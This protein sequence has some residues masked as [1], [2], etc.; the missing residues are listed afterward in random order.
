MLH[1]LCEYVAAEKAGMPTIFI[2]GYY[3]RT[4]V[5]GHQVFGD[6]RYLERAL[7]YGDWLLARQGGDGFWKT[8]YGDIYLADT[9][10]ALGLLMVLNRHADPGRQAR[11]RA[12][13]Q[14]Y[15]AAVQ[16]NRLIQ[17]SGAFGVGFRTKA[18]GT[19]LVP[20][21]DEYTISSALS[22]GVVCTWLY[23][24]TQDAR[25]RELAHQA[26]GWI[27]STQRDDGAIPY[28]L[29]GDG[30]DLAKR[31]DPATDFVLW[32]KHRF[33]AVAYVGEAVI[34]FDRYC[35]QPAWRRRLRDQ[36]GATVEFLLRT[37]NADGT[38][39]Y[40]DSENPARSYDQKRSPGVSHLLVWYYTNVRADDRVA[41]AVR[42]FNAF[43]LNRAN[44]R[45]FGLLQ[46]GGDASNPS[47]LGAFT[48]NDVVTALTGRALADM[49]QPGI[50]AHW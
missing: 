50:D 13:M 7:T 16:A 33:Q 3:M 4:L 49:L 41:A 46:A 21:R 2:G 28:V 10:S 43:L 38:W 39:G 26:L 11:Y 40:K 22:G 25:Y 47:P 44:Q 9:G 1:D 19:V 18:Q 48:Q 37:Q 8:G 29:K 23:H 6:R 42:R 14:R 30:G 27:M 34:A 36:A 31:G 12:A 24:A 32:E 20:W 15:I 5:A 17:P 35:D 45:G